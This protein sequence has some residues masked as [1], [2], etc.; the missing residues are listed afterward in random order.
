MIGSSQ[1]IAR[2]VAVGVSHAGT[3]RVALGKVETGST[4]SAICNAIFRCETSCKHEV[5]HE[6]IFLAMQ[7]NAIALQGKLPR[8]TWP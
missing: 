5:S 7:C 3:C 6:G 2:Q 8:V 1:N 4:F